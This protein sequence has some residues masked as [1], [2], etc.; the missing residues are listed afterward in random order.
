MQ[1][2]FAGIGGEPQPFHT[3]A[4]VPSAALFRRLLSKLRD[5]DYS[6]QIKVATLLRFIRTSTLQ[7]ALFS[8]ERFVVYLRLGLAGIRSAACWRVWPKP[9]ASSIWFGCAMTSIER[10][11]EVASCLASCSSSSSTEG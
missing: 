11:S 2:L 7:H 1:S 10:V 8:L 6:C 4:Q 3:V 5:A 9:R